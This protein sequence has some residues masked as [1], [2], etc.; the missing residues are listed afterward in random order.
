MAE[1]LKFVIHK[2]TRTQD[3]HWDLM[4]QPP[5]KNNSDARCSDHK[6]QTYRLELPPEK[7]INDQT[8]ATKIFDHPQRFLT[9]QG[10]VNK[11][12]GS[13]ELT[14]SGTYEILNHEKN[15][16]QLLFDGRILKGKFSLNHTADDNWSFKACTD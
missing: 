1:K 13:V 9:Y 10:P 4:L 7:L 8:T 14:D 15:K 16:I 6:L 2:H 11:S 5:T 12:R 3:I